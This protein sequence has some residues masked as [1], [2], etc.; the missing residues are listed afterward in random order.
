MKDY[1]EGL[2]NTIRD[3]NDDLVIKNGLRLWDRAIIYPVQGKKREM[4]LNRKSYLFRLEKE[5]SFYCKS[6][7]CILPSLQFK[8]AVFG[9]YLNDSFDEN[10]KRYILKS[11][12]NF[13]FKLNGNFCYEAH[14][15]Q[16]DVLDLGYNRIKFQ[17]SDGKQS[18][19]FYQ[20]F[21]SENIVLSGLNILLLGETG[22]GKSKMAERIHYQGKRRG[23][24]VQINPASF[25]EG[26]IESELFG[27]VQG[28]FTGASRYK[29]GAI[30]HADKGTLFIDEIDSLPLSIQVKLL[31]FLD[32]KK[33]RNVGSHQDERVDVRLIFASGRGLWDLVK[34]KKMRKDFYY[35]VT[36]GFSIIL[37]P[38]RYNPKRI[39]IICDDY[40]Q[41]TKSIIPSELIDFYMTCKWPGNIRQLIGHL[42][43][44]RTIYNKRKW[45]FDNFDKQLAAEFSFEELDDKN[46]LTMEEIKISYAYRTYLALGKRY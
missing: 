25:C 41:K 28:A 10:N 45:E 36:S 37:E 4:I 22:T 19:I 20:N 39:K 34:E 6:Y 1:M 35:R 32:S 46:F 40:L 16:G 3:F 23:N 9:M 29:T 42:D 26:L 38:L 15:E 30:A 44:K 27:H 14:L 11:L 7:T 5:A 24:F 17:R 43:K 31:I 8:E 21:P 12:N 18:G 33:I 13:P 2:N